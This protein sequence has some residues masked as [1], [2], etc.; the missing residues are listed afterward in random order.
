MSIP[1]SSIVVI[2]NF[3]AWEVFHFGSLFYVADQ[4]GALHRV[5]DGKKD[6]SRSSIASLMDKMCSPRSGIA[7]VTVAID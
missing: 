6:A 2:F 4:R 7:L 3:A 1:D 5:A